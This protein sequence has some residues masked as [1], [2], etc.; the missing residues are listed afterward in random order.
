MAQAK[1]YGAPGEYNAPL[2]TDTYVF[3]D[4]GLIPNNSLPLIVR[5]AAIRPSSPDPAKAFENTFQKNGWTNSWRNGIHDY[6]HYHSTAHEVLGIAMGSGSVRF[7]GESGEL[8]AVTAGDVVVI[9]AGVGHALIND[10]GELLV[11]GAYAGGRDWDEIRDDP[12]AIEAARKRIAEVPLPDA[13][14]VDGA[15]GPLMKLWSNG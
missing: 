11:V 12:G 3:K 9:P 14:P 6:H 15:N 4:N 8:V 10:N 5:R 13:D 2:K 7:G 1:G